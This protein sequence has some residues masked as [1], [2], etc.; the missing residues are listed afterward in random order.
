[1]PEADPP[2]PEQSTASQRRVLSA[3]AAF[4]VGL[5]MLDA[6]DL[7]A[8][9]RKRVLTLQSVPAQVRSTLRTAF[10]AGLQLVA[11]ETSAES[12]L[13]GW[14][15]FYLAARMLLHRAPAEAR[16]P[17]AE[18]ERRCELVRRGE[19]PCL[20]AAAEAALRTPEADSLRASRAEVEARATRATA[21]V[22]LGELS[23]AARALVSQ[24]LAPGSSDTLQELHDPA[25]R[26]QAPYAPPDPMLLAFRPEEQCALRLH[27]FLASLRTARRGSAAGPS[28]ITNEHLR[29]LLDDEADCSL[30]HRAAER[31]ARADVPVPVVAAIRAGRI[32]ALRKPNGRVRA[33]VVGDVLRRLV[34]RTLAQE[35]ASEL[36]AA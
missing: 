13:R 29:M 6:V 12:T 32:V 36:Q 18:L 5:Q 23:A 33:L 21:L 15:L 7:A 2:A 20:L 11:D 16:I 30:L 22:H 24:P 3:E 28:G 10:R 27:P 1:M 34:G 14:K 9:L 17:T 35:Y 25:N 4:H 8:T 31:L 26:P 19:W